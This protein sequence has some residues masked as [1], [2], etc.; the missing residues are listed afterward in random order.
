[1]AAA[2]G[3]RVRLWEQSGAIGGRLAL[4]SRLRLREDFGLWL[5]HAAGRLSALGVRL[6]LGREATASALADAHPEC[7]VLAT[8]ARPVPYCLPDGGVALTLDAAAQMQAWGKRIAIYDETGDWPVLG[9]TEQHPAEQGAEVT[10]ITPIA[11]VLWRTTI[12]SNLTTFARY[13]A[14]RIRI[15]P[16]SR[17]VS[18]ANGVLTL[19]NASCGETST[20]G[21]DTIVGCVA[22][23]AHHRSRCCSSRPGS[24][25]SS[26]ATASPRATRWR[27]SSTATALRWPRSDPGADVN[28]LVTGASGFV[29]ANLVER[30]SGR[31]PLGDR[32]RG[33]SD[34]RGRAGRV[35]SLPGQA[36]VGPGRRA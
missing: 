33:E 17:P 36:A 3:H 20:L 13:R 16:L 24:R 8:G 6:E 29:G 18:F 31:R 21:V 15:L 35:R 25:R 14:K 2:R 27:R 11:G 22:P 9:L 10:L 5:E 7:I 26:S 4:A 1:M 12:Y 34:A 19:E 23:E 28:I 30:L 32:A